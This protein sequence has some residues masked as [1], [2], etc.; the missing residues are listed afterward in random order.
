M[1]KF[2]LLSVIFASLALAGCVAEDN[3]EEIAELKQ[4]IEALKQE[5]SKQVEE[6]KVTQGEPRE[7]FFSKNMACLNLREQAKTELDGWSSPREIEALFYSPKEQEC[8]ILVH[9][10]WGNSAHKSLYRL[11]ELA[12]VGHPIEGCIEEG[13]GLCDNFAK[14]II[15]TYK[16]E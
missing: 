5:N 14:E 13:F 15:K 7:D 8:L 9:R 16:N 6:K 4:E 1:K 3:S 12:N 2:L 10:D 11:S